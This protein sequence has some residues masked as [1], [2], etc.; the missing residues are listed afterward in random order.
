MKFKKK[1]RKRNNWRVLKQS[2]KYTKTSLQTSKEDKR[3][4]CTE[5]YYSCNSE[6]SKESADSLLF[7][8]YDTLQKWIFAGNV[9]YLLE[10]SQSCTLCKT[11]LKMQ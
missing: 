7:H 6:G 9:Y 10:K 4:K 8:V 3:S 1:K 5:I 2:L 11:I